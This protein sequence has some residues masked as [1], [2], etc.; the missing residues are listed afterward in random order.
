MKATSM[1]A[2]IIWKSM[3]LPGDLRRRKER[4]GNRSW[5]VACV[6]AS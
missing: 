3:F 5:M 4:R 2:A 1:F 6:S